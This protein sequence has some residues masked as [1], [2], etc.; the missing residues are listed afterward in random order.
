M[1]YDQQQM[2]LSFYRSIDI[3]G[4]GRV[5][6]QEFLKF[7]AENGYNRYVPAN[8]FKLLDKNND[9][10]LD[11]EECLTF[12]YMIKGQR[13]VKCD[14]CG[15]YLWGLYFLYDECYHITP[16]KTFDLCCS[17]YRNRKFNHVHSAAS[18]LDNYALLRTLQFQVDH[19]GRATY[20]NHGL[21]TNQFEW[22]NLGWNICQFLN[23]N[24]SQQ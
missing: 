21:G 3:N 4:D 9:G 13:L 2:L 17:C 11:F 10:T 19:N 7:L 6:N 1:S 22:F 12:F 8:L 14:G 5:S 18:F 20:S 24:C 23:S 16:A 15:S